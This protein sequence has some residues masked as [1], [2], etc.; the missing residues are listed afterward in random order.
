MKKSATL[1]LLGIAPFVCAQQAAEQPSAPSIKLTDSQIQVIK[2][3]L[4]QLEKDVSKNRNSS[5]GAAVS[6]LQKAMG[7]EADARDLYM[8]CYKGVHFERRD[9]KESDYIEW[10]T[11]N[12]AKLKDPEFLMGL[13][14][15]AEYL[16]LSIQAQEAKEIDSIIPKLQDFIAKELATVS[17]TVKRGNGGAVTFDKKST[18]STSTKTG[19]VQHSIGSPQ[20][21]DM[22][23]RNVKASEFAKYYMLDEFLK[24][25][26]WEY[27]PM[28]FPGI[29]RNVVFPFYR[30]KKPSE[31]AAQW[32]TMIKY[33]FSLEEASRAETDYGIFYKERLPERQWE[34]ANDLFRSNINS[35]GALADM[36][37]IVRDN[38]THPKAAEWLRKI[39]ETVNGSQG[40]IPPSV[41]P[42][43]VTPQPG[44][45]P[46]A[47]PQ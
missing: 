40:D 34:K 20:V 16:V 19:R 41:A 27:Q 33:E 38:P 4:E 35:V 39:R 44:E 15:Q 37:K 25:K 7:S 3:Q 17:S 43:V 12:Q 32:D 21:L 24:N 30:E 1:L 8:A 42:P 9:L 13:R 47:P 11:K 29:Y 45:A 23:R 46:V 5:L 18:T 22:L 28:D 26:D 10:K 14:L 36:I 6:A 2:Q 31:L